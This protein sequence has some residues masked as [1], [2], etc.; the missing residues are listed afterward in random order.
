MVFQYQ[1]KLIRPVLVTIIYHY[2]FYSKK[3]L[4]VWLYSGKQIEDSFSIF[5]N[6]Y[7]ICIFI[8]RSLIYH[9]HLWNTKLASAFK[10]QYL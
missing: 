6:T 9:K 5:S 1:C 10:L 8:K 3:W 4:I 7:F 2:K